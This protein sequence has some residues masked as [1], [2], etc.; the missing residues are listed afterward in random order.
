M[1]DLEINELLKQIYYDPKTGLQV[2]KLYQKAKA[3]NPNVTHKMVK[4]FL[5]EQSTA[6]IFQRRT[7]K[8]HYPLIAD[9]PFQRI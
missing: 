6:Q 5:A 4:E 1:T 2:N 8:H 7:V 9:Y 3:I